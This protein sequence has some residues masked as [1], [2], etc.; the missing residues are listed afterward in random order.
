MIALQVWSCHLTQ[1]ANFEKFLFFFLILHLILEKV[2]KFLAKSSLLQKL[3]AET[4]RESGNP[5]MT[6]NGANVEGK[7]FLMSNQAE[8]LTE[9]AFS[10]ALE[11]LP[12]TFNNLKY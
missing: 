2:K 9:S 8:I 10:K 5:L 7:Y 12:V 6:L 11:L 1:D 4:S 3:S